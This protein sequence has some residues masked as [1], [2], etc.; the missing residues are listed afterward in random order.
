MAQIK[1]GTANVTNNSAVVTGNGT[2]WL[3]NL[4]AGKSSFKI[5]GSDVIY[6]VA[7]VDSDT[8]IHLTTVYAGPSAASLNYICGIDYTPNYDLYEPDFHDVDW[9]VHLRDSV[10]KIDTVLNSTVNYIDNKS[11]KYVITEEIL[12]KQLSIAEYSSNGILY[13][14]DADTIYKSIDDGNTWI[15]LKSFTGSFIIRCLKVAT[16]GSIYV[17]PM[18]FNVSSTDAGI[19]R[20]LDNGVTWIKVLNLPGNIPNVSIQS[21]Y[22][23]WQITE[24]ITGSLFASIYTLGNGI[25]PFV[26]QSDDNGTTWYVSYASLGGICKSS[27]KIFVSMRT[28]NLNNPIPTTDH[29]NDGLLSNTYWR[30]VDNLFYSYLSSKIPDYSPTTN[31]IRGRRHGHQI[32]NK[33]SIIYFVEGDNTYQEI[34]PSNQFVHSVGEPL[35]VKSID[36]GTNWTAVISAMV[37]DGSILPIYTQQITSIY[38]TDSYIIA[39]WESWYTRVITKTDLTT[40]TTRVVLVKPISMMWDY[41]L[42]FISYENLLLCPLMGTPEILV[43][44]DAGE[45]WDVLVVYS[46]ITGNCGIRTASNFNN[47]SIIITLSL[48]S[49]FGNTNTNGYYIQGIPYEFARKWT[50]K[51][52]IDSDVI[53]KTAKSNVIAEQITLTDDTIN[54]S[55]INKHGFVPKLSGSPTDVFYGDGTWKNITPTGISYNKSFEI[56]TPNQTIIAKL[57]LESSADD[58]FHAPSLRTFRSRTNNAG[59][60]VDDTLGGIAVQGMDSAGL[61]RGGGGFYFQA[62]STWTPTSIAS[63]FILILTDSSAN[64]TGYTPISIADYVVTINNTV[65]VTNLVF[66]DNTTQTTAATGVIAAGASGCV[67]YNNGAGGLA[68]HNSFFYTT[69]MLYVDNITVSYTLT[70]YDLVLGNSTPSFVVNNLTST[71]TNKALSAA[72]GKVL[73]DRNPVLTANYIP[74]STG[75]AT[76]GDAALT[77]DPTYSALTVSS[78]STDTNKGLITTQHNTGVNGAS[79]MFIKSRGTKTSQENVIDG[80]Y[81]GQCIFSGYGTQSGSGET[82]GNRQ[83]AHIRAKVT[84]AVDN[85]ANPAVIPTDLILLCGSTVSTEKVRI[86]A[87]GE[88]RVGGDTF[89]V[90]SSGITPEGGFYTCYTA[91]EALVAGD[92]VYFAQSGAADAVTKI[93]ANGDMPIGV[94]YTGAANGTGVQIVWGGRVAVMFTSA[95]S[96]G[97]IGYVSASVAGQLDGASS[98]PATT[99]HFRE[100]GHT[101]GASISKE[102]RTLYYVQL[103][104]N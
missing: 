104:F 94:V 48:T 46:N 82:T 75:S 1:T 34:P 90:G 79:L 66:S 32:C 22:G 80:D 44:T 24:G 81:L 71:F 27:G 65:K 72:Q 52:G 98:V 40:G 60:I 2:L 101:T 97:Y 50:I 91:A 6:T 59:V 76:T 14:A 61:W 70:A 38:P 77:Y 103:Q 45:T 17:S 78:E 55:S 11:L 67:Q 102:S 7:S 4:T 93:P 49:A 12:S 87:N 37:D 99:T 10:R 19:W 35:L 86:K 43:S 26:F 39:S 83:R 29:D 62:N 23:A 100:C 36:N 9:P 96:K 8:Q 56:S 57:A 51:E 5:N 47:N 84:G 20:S 63:K 15:S 3:T 13:G 16:N 73:S 68:G 28:E 64:G 58:N 21:S 25:C 92:V 33:G 18:G 89:L 85:T 95:P 88:V 30:E 41:C 31:Y 74:F 42:K 54:N 69:G 53:L